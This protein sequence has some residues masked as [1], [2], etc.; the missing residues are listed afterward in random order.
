ME[1]DKK[2]CMYD[3][4]LEEKGVLLYII[5][6]RKVITK[7]FIDYAMRHEIE[8]VII[9]GSGTS[10]HAALATRKFMEDMLNI[11]VRAEYPMM[12]KD[13]QR[14]YNR[15]T[16][17]IGVSQGGN[18]NSTISAM[19]K[20]RE[21]GC[22]TVAISENP[23]AGVFHHADT[24]VMMECGPELSVAKTKG[25]I[26]TLGLLFIMGLELALA[27]K[28][29]TDAQ[30]HDYIARLEKTAD[31]FN[32][33]IAAATEWVNAIK[34]E[35]KESRRLIVVGYQNNYA[36]VLEGALKMLET[37]RFGICGYEIEE[38]FH[39]IY[40]SINTDT[41]MI[42]LASEG[43]YKEKVKRLRSVLGEITSHNF[44]ITK[45]IEGYEPTKKDCIVDFIDDEYFSVFEYILPMQII[46]SL[47]PEEL[48]IN[49][50]FPS[51]PG[52]HQKM[53][54]K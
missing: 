22:N 23:Q 52:F 5:H 26:A 46:S 21:N 24:K 15:K 48:G 9:S 30:Y 32:S 35:L 2:I 40:N 37:M 17:F 1:N 20:A 49:P 47:I 50:F 36:N 29:I 11:R 10:Y 8:E 51:D 34:D 27:K 6:E 54:S 28:T 18:S 19:Q 7:D 25:Y 42:Y 43:R 45:G 31:N 3:Y 4:I 53:G 33:I 16:L 38:F 39:G 44:V 14:V 12:F 41:Y 13:L